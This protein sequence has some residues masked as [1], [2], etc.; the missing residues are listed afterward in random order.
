LAPFRH[1]FVLTD[2]EGA[3]QVTDW[4][5]TREDAPGLEAARE[6][7]TGEVNAFAAGLLR[8]AEAQGFEAPR[9]TIWDG[10]G[11]G[12]LR[13]DGIE[14]PSERFRHDDPR[15][16]GGVFLAARNAELPADA[17]VFIGQH[18]MEG[19]GGNLAHTYSSRRVKRH[20]LNGVEIGEFGT[21]ALN[22]WA[23]GVPTVFFSGDDVACKEATGLIP[24]LVSVEVKQTRSVTEADSLSHDESCRALAAAA[25][26]I[27]T[28]DPADP[29]LT[30]RDLPDAPYRYRRVRRAKWGLLPL[31]DR[32]VEGHDL[33]EVLG[34]V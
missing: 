8:S 9:L 21:R 20:L 30:P 7:L 1:V 13:L 17:L 12:G 24:G 33:A 25:G 31:P 29:A 23:L 34:R 6:L 28:L 15:G 16:F 5:Q 22:A 32:V 26:R 10:H 18:A 27:W 14:V 3:A 4:R 2:L 11:P 19:T